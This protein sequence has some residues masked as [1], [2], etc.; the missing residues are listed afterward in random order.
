MNMVSIANSVG[1]YEDHLAAVLRWYNIAFKGKH[2]PNV[3]DEETFNLLSVI[4]TDLV[5]ENR[6]EIEHERD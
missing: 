6:E 3:K 5:R 1:I 4:H 2:S